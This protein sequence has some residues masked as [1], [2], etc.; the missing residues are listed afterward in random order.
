LKGAFRKQIDVMTLVD[1]IFTRAKQSLT[2]F[3]RC[4]FIIWKK[5]HRF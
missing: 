1:E 2:A 4:T 3:I 5:K